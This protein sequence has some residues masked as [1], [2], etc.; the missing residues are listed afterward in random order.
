MML[1]ITVIN[2][3]ERPHIESIK[4]LSCLEVSAFRKGSYA[5]LVKSIT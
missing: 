2:D 5:E 3:A 4:T 1:K